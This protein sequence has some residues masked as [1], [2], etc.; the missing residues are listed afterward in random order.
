MRIISDRWN[1]NG[2]ISSGDYLRDVISPNMMATKDMKEKVKVSVTG[3]GTARGHKR[4]KERGDI[5]VIAREI[6]EEKVW[7]FTCGRTQGHG[8]LYSRCK[9][10]LADGT[11]KLM[12]GEVIHRWKHDSALKRGFAEQ[13]GEGLGNEGEHGVR[14]R[15]MEA[16]EE[17]DEPDRDHSRLFD[18]FEELGGAVG[19][20]DVLEDSDEE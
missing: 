8:S 9:D 17:D 1:P 15:D 4:A 5:V 16:E 11:A 3:K 10:L 14:F 2:N 18:L 19:D 12:R 7:K 20:D 13:N 6:R